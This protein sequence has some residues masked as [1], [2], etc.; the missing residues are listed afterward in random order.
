MFK[1]FNAFPEAKLYDIKLK[2]NTIRI[3]K[4]NR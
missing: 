4:L 3:Q 2:K 1:V